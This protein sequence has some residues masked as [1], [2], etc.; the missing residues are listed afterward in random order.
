LPDACGASAGGWTCWRGAGAATRRASGCGC[1]GIWAVGASRDPAFTAVGVTDATPIVSAGVFPSS[2][3]ADA[4]VHAA[5][6]RIANDT[7]VGD[8]GHAVVVFGCA[9]G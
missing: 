2:I 1:G 8:I 6:V 7:V 3:D 4:A 5:I 9:C